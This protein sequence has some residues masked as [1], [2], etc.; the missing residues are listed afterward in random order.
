MIIEYNY[1]D[2][3]NYFQPLKNVT[4]ECWNWCVEEKQIVFDNFLKSDILLIPLI[5]ITI[6]LAVTFRIRS[7]KEISKYD[8]MALD[9]S[10]Y[11]MI[12]YLIYI[13]F[14]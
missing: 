12:G 6:I 5:A 11:I 14:F 10:T 1:S 9:F 13:V 8:I 2:V 3:S 7:G 4:S